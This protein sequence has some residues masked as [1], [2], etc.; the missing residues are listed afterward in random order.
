MKRLLLNAVYIHSDVY[1][2]NM[3]YLRKTRSLDLAQSKLYRLHQVSLTTVPINKFDFIRSQDH[4]VQRHRETF[5]NVCCYLPNKKYVLRNNSALI[6]LVC[7]KL[8][9]YIIHET[10]EP[11]NSRMILITY[12]IHVSNS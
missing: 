12:N 8:C 10:E 4:T 7:V 1:V 5:E 6:L 9:P 3:F 2:C 11:N